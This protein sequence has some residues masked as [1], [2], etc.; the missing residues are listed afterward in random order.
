MLKPFS[1]TFTLTF[2]QNFAA[3]PE[4]GFNPTVWINEAFE[5]MEPGAS[6]ESF[7]SSL[8]FKLQ[9]F[10]QEVNSALDETSQQILNNLP[11]AL[12]ESEA[13]ATESQ[14]LKI[15]L[16]SLKLDLGKVERDSS[17]SIRSVTDIETVKNRIQD[18]LTCL[19]ERGTLKVIDDSQLQN[20]SA[21]ASPLLTVPDDTDSVHSDAGSIQ[22]SET[23]DPQ[24][25]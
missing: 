9:L 14:Q 21:R 11:K 17:D 15:Q 22:N 23:N 25:I 20:S 1:E 16:E 24:I 2:L 3:F 6:Y 13:I 18:T 7:A 12:R 8:V 4:E 10:V 5:S 19:S